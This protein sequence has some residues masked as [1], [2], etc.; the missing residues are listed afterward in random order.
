MVDIIILIAF[1]VWSFVVFCCNVGMIIEEE[2][3]LRRSIFWID[4]ITIGF[5]LM[6]LQFI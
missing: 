4:V 6:I 1:G 2:A 3:D 5:G